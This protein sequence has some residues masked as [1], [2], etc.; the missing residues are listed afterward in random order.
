MPPKLTA[1]Q[2]KDRIIE[3]VEW[4]A[5]HARLDVREEGVYARGHC[6]YASSCPL[7]RLELLVR[8][9]VPRRAAPVTVMDGGEGLAERAADHLAAMGYG[10]ISVLDGGLS[11]WEAAGFELFGG[12]NVPS[13]AFGELVEQTNATPHVTAHQLKIMMDR[14]DDMVVPRRPS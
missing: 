5:E 14:G 12:M 13:K 8:D 1:T 10:D 7:C 9:M 6:L 3:A 2:E 11:A 4:R